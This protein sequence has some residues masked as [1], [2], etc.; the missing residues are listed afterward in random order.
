MANKNIDYKQLSSE[1]DSVL[2]KL[3]AGDVDVDEAVKLYERGMEITEQLESYLKQ[4]ENTVTKIKADW[5]KGK[6]Q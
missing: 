4:A 6:E 5:G 1:L 2:D 3:Q